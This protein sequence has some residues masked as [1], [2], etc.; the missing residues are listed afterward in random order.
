MNDNHLEGSELFKMLVRIEQRL[1]EMEKLLR[2]PEPDNKQWDYPSCIS[3]NGRTLEGPKD[4][5]TCANCSKA[6]TI[7]WDSFKPKKQQYEMQE[8][9]LN[10]KY[11]HRRADYDQPKVGVKKHGVCF[12]QYNVSTGHIWVESDSC[13]KFEKEEC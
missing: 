13:K 11:W 5:W 12:K 1:W 4:Y 10:C 9:C 8:I 2:A 7:E 6:M 3:C